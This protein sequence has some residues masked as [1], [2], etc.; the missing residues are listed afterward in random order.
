MIDRLKTHFDEGRPTIWCIAYIRGCDKFWSLRIDY[1]KD[2]R[3]V[4]H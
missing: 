4:E 2:A 3:T 1:Q